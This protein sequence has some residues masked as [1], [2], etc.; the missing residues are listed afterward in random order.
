MTDCFDCKFSTA[1]ITTKEMCALDFFVD[2]D[3]QDEMVEDIIDKVTTWY[4]KHIYSEMGGRCAES[5]IDK[6]VQ[7]CTPSFRTGTG[8][9]VLQMTDRGYFNSAYQKYCDKTNPHEDVIF[10]Q[11]LCST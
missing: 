1:K 11:C 10:N 8:P 4:S 5:D 6:F 2:Q 3:V 9:R 7:L